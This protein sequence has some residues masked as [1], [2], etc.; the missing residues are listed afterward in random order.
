MSREETNAT[1]QTA[2]SH[3]SDPQ[4]A[5]QQKQQQ[6]NGGSLHDVTGMEARVERAGKLL[7]ATLVFYR[8]TILNPI[9]RSY[10]PPLLKDLEA[11]IESESSPATR[12][13]SRGTTLLEQQSSSIALSPSG[14][15]GPVSLADQL[16]YTTIN[17]RSP[18]HSFQ[19]S[20]A[21][22][23]FYGSVESPRQLLMVPK[24]VLIHLLFQVQC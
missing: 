22:C 4:P 9:A 8:N 5:G 11:Y 16:F 18:L 14:P 2:G 15:K 17:L 12:H 7:A 3:S 23:S 1:D 19:M 6:Y 24:C 13:L 20:I 10:P 21:V